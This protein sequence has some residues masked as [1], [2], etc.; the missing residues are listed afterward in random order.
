MKRR[1]TIISEQ[2]KVDPGKIQNKLWKEKKETEKSKPPRDHKN[3]KQRVNLE[4]KM[5]QKAK[6]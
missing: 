5:Q 4:D 1:N 3:L 6:P 2:S